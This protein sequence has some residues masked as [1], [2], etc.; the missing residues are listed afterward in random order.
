MLSTREDAIGATGAK[1][2]FPPDEGWEP[3]TWYLV[4]VS[5][6]Y[7]NPVHM[8]LFHSGFLNDEGKPH[9]YNCLIP[10][11]GVSSGDHVSGIR[12]ARYLRVIRILYQGSMSKEEDLN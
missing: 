8:S 1:G 10:L 5:F 2:I 9:G 11:I 4:A 12:E 6:K 7:T 3:H